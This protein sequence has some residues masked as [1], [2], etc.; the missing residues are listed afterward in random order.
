MSIESMMTDD[1]DI[2]TPGYKT[3]SRNN[4]VEDWTIATEVSSKGWMSQTN[5]SAPDDELGSSREG[6]IT[7]WRLFLPLGKV[8]DNHCRIRY[9][10]TLF[11]IVGAPHYA[12]TPAS[13]HHIEVPLRQVVG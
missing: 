10:G 3:D 12:K 4:R 8:L 11:E 9:L 7:E 5:A 13:F 1:V 2:I 6:T